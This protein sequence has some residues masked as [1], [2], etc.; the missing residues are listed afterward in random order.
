MLGLDGSFV[1]YQLISVYLVYIF[2]ICDEAKCNP[3]NFQSL[4]G[5]MTVTSRFVG[6]SFVHQSS[7]V[8]K[9]KFL[10]VIRF[11]MDMYPA[12]SEVGIAGWTNCC[13][14]MTYVST[15]TKSELSARC[16]NPE[17]PNQQRERCDARCKRY[18]QISE[19]LREILTGAFALLPGRES[20]E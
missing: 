10:R 13:E 2:D 19:A 4:F 11:C 20:R 17:I 1:C 6:G 12:S 16:Y 18:L 5:P 7:D 3:N 8:V 15:M 14:K 9:S